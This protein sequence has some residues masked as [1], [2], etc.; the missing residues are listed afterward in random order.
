MG[1][2]R[3]VPI[4]L[5]DLQL[6]KPTCLFSVPTLYKKVYDGVNNLVESASPLRRKLMKSA[7]EMGEAKVLADNG[8]GPRLSSIERI[9]LSVLDRLVLS[10]IRNRF[11]GNLQKGF[12]GGAAVPAEVVSFMDSIGIPICEGYG[13][14]ETSPIMT[15]NVPEKRKIG[16]V[17]RALGD[18]MVYIVDENG[19]PVAP[20]EEGE[21]CCVGP[22]VMKGYYT[23]QEATD[24]VISIAPDGKSRMFHTG[25]QGKMDEEGWVSVTGR[26]KEQ[27]K[28]ENGKYV[29]PS[30]IESAISMSR[31][32]NQVVLCGAN[33]P[34]NVALLVPEWPAIRTELN[35][36]GDVIDE[37][38]ANDAKVKELIDNEIIQSCIKLKKFEIPKEFAFVAPFT[39]ANNMLTPKMSIRRHKVMEA[40]EELISS[41]YDDDPIVTEAAD[42]ALREAA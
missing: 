9:K 16:S 36:D 24:E 31:F 27:Y 5:E 6:V 33:R 2:C 22:N 29:V 4:I 37:Q 32:I 7:L 41:M 17:G 8:T 30:P 25:D 13:L 19:Q 1:I 40:Y 21:I 12:S 42:G 3:G 38:L 20:G 23:N 11:G 35:I 10:K 26:I 18:V 15:L 28:L 39:A 34:F 14:T